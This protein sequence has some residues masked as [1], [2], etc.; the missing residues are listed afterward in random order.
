[1]AD[2]F[3]L[4]DQARAKTR[5]LVGYFFIAV[6]LIVIAVNLAVWFAANVGGVI[7]ISLD[8]WPYHHYSWITTAIVLSLIFITSAIQ[9]AR[10]SGGG[11][12]VAEMVGARRVLP[13]TK[14]KH[15]RRLLNITEEMSIA[16]GMPMPKVFIM[17]DELGINAFVAGL[18]PSLT[19][20]VV[21]QGTLK[22]L[23]RDELQGV[24]G[25]EF[26]HIFN[27]DMSINV[28]LIGMLAGILVIGQMGYGLMRILG[29]SRLGYGSRGSSKS[30]NS[31]ANILLFIVVLGAAL[32]A[33]GYIGLF[34][35]RLIKASISRQREYL[36]DASSVQFTRDTDGITKALAHI[37][38][39]SEKGLLHN[40]HAEDMS[41]MCFDMPI[42]L[43]LNGWL[44]T[45]PPLTERI[46]ALNPNFSIQDYHPKSTI[47]DDF[48]SSDYQTSNFSSG[49]NIAGFAGTS[50]DIPSV[51]ATFSEANNTDTTLSQLTNSIG[52][53]SP[54]NLVT[55][56]IILDQIP[57]EIL[58]QSSEDA[59]KAQLVVYALLV[60]SEPEDKKEI[61]QFLES[62]LPRNYY[63]TY[64][65]WTEQLLSLSG[66]IRLPLLNHV[67]PVLQLCSKSELVLFFDTVLTIIKNN[68]Q[69]NL[70][71][72]IIYALLM[73]RLRA[74]KPKT[75]IPSLVEV[76]PELGLIFSLM[77]NI[78]YDDPIVAK[79]QYN[80]LMQGFAIGIFPNYSV[81][82]FNAVSTHNALL[83]LARLSPFLKR[84]IIV[85][86]GDC[87]NQ[88]NTVTL[89]EYEL[90]RAVCDYLDCPLPPL[91]LDSSN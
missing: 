7:L 13:G 76:K 31:G 90:L 83:R 29:R 85:S 25:H 67:I 42:S 50:N 75:V 47:S 51:D 28:R 84:N 21:T 22:K 9:S 30:S 33:I 18:K 82:N 60:H 63:Q 14:D 58:E 23:S 8:Q 38:V 61:N 1:V 45:H 6:I 72:Y 37:Q 32:F 26:S 24:I 81:Q 11:D 68:K 2:F 20:L 91:N 12:A 54:E 19:I 62:Q 10:L 80:N 39:D 86:L 41:H 43:S 79:E 34:F 48:S 78:S 53:P 49:A 40:K 56:S 35:G 46:K 27:S 71:E 57:N 15:E 59:I 16:S 4:Q 55:A 88:N 87:I 77:L 70:H 5:T 69:V 52:N 74:P 44:A 36:A 3:E 65:N 64:S 89:D 17:D 73:K 66:W